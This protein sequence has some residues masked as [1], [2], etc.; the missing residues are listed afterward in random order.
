MQPFSGEIRPGIKAMVI[1]GFNAGRCVKV[2]ELIGDFAQYQI[3][4]YKD[5]LWLAELSG[6]YFEVFG[7]LQQHCSINGFLSASAMP[8]AEDC[9]M[10]LP[11]LNEEQ[12]QQTEK[13][14]AA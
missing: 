11:P 7:N 12:T 2:G 13:K 1:K 4:G 9:L 6:R 5:D 10:P 14:V 3:F 8:M